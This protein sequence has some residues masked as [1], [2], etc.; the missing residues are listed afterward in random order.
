MAYDGEVLVAIFKDKL[1]FNLAFEQNWY[2]IPVSS[3]EKW[4]KNRWP[5]QWLA[6]Y[7]TKKVFPGEP[8]A[9]TYYAQVL[10]IRS[11]YRFELFPNEP[12]DGKGLNRYYQ[13]ILG[14]LRKL[15]QPII[16]QRWRFIVFIPTTWQKFIN[17]T[18]INDLY[19]ESPLEDKLW[20][21]LKRLNVKAERQEHVKIKR[22]NYFLDFAIY[23]AGGKIDVETDGDTYHTTKEQAKQDNIRHN[24]LVGDGWRQLR[25]NTPEIHE[26]MEEYCLQEIVDNIKDLGGVDEGGSVPRHISLNEPGQ[27]RQLG[28]FDR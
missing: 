13:L 27:A 25:F 4:M 21:E 22:R 11:A 10:D 9:I 19:N 18:E 6:F 3:A 16:S 5:P 12:H 8:F 7:Q 28:L 2:R 1:D 23:C 14:P 24:D 26:R 15:P 17:A 20:N